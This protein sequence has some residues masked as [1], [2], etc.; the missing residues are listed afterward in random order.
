MNPSA[1]RSGVLIVRLWIEANHPQ[2][3]RARI[4]QTLDSM[5]GEES[6]A[7]A[8][9]ADDICTIVKR[10]VEDFAR[11]DAPGGDGRARPGRDGEG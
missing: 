1:D 8:A 10:W 2:G 4:T 11:P 3:L 9:S 7:L 6:V 5:A